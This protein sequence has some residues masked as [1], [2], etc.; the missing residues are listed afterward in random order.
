MGKKL[1]CLLID[2]ES[3]GSLLICIVDTD[4]DSGN[5]N[6]DAKA[7]A[8][9]TGAAFNRDNGYKHQIIMRDVACT[10][11]TCPILLI[12]I[13]EFPNICRHCTGNLLV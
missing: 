6:R 9:T 2:I 8:V 3:H 4:T 1:G 5:Q 11:Q 12:V 13:G 10:R 7:N